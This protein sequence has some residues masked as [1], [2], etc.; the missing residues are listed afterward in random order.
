MAKAT[1]RLG[2]AADK[3]DPKAAEQL[4]TRIMVVKQMK[5]FSKVEYRPL[6]Q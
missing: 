3:N 1:F 4:L 2:A 5:N 6:I